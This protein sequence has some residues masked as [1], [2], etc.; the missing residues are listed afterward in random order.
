ML[1]TKIPT[2]DAVA[3]FVVLALASYKVSNHI[4]PWCHKT[5]PREKP[6]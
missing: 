2:W 5:E 3:M 6:F 4:P 1:L